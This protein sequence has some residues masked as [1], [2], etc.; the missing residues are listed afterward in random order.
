MNEQLIPLVVF[1]PIFAYLGWYDWR[2]GIVQ[3]KVIYPVAIFAIALNLMFSELSWDKILGGGFIA[4]IFGLI[5]LRNMSGA[6]DVKFMAVVGFLFGFPLMAAVVGG[7][8]LLA[9]PT[10]LAFGLASDPKQSKHSARLFNYYRDK[11]LAF[12]PLLA[13]SSV[14]VASWLIFAMVNY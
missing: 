8:F 11:S 4:L 9:I 7:A 5:A 3:N 12:G 13:I 10:M 2:Y 6:G 14:I 1:I